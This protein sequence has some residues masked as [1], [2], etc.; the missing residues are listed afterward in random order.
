MGEQGNVGAAG[1]FATALS[2]HDTFFSRL[3]LPNTRE[4]ERQRTCVNEHHHDEKACMYGLWAGGSKGKLTQS[5]FSISQ[6]QFHPLH[7]VLHAGM[8]SSYSVC[9]GLSLQ[10]H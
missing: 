10:S 2:G 3:Q 4:K 6:V 1:S 8:K 9:N 5:F 7:D